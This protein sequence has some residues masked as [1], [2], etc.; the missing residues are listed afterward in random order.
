MILTVIGCL[1]VACNGKHEPP[2]ATF[3]YWRT[4]FYLTDIEQQALQK[5]EVG[6]MYI[7]YFDVDIDSRGKPHPVSAIH[8]K[9]SPENLQIVPV[10]YIKNRV[11][12]KDNLQLDLMADN[13]CKYIEQ[14]NKAAE[15]GSIDEIQIDCD[16]TLTSRDKFMQFVEIGRASCRERV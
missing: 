5:N 11:M 14:I 12:L 7:R 4:V 9:E 1:F 6:K 2:T 8:F 13:I 15:I 10:V 3:Y 16:W